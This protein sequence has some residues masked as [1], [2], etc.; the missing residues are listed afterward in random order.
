M[1]PVWTQAVARS[2]FRPFSR[3]PS[4]LPGSQPLLQK[5]GKGLG[6]VGKMSKFFSQDFEEYVCLCY[7]LLQI[8][9]LYRILQDTE[10]SSLCLQ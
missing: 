9:L 5:R 1:L 7:F 10:C 2:G 6:R 3:S 4:G 8:L